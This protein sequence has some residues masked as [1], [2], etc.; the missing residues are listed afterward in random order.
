MRWLN[1]SE[2]PSYLK[3]GTAHKLKMKTEIPNMIRGRLLAKS[4]QITMRGCVFVCNTSTMA[5]KRNHQ[6]IIPVNM[7]IMI[8]IPEQEF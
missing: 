5:V 1:A 2:I 4:N 7:P 6:V 3:S 8:H